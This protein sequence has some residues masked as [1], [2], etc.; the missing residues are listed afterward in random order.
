MV[1]SRLPKEAIIPALKSSVVKGKTIGFA[2][3]AIRLIVKNL[4]DYEEMM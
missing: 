1:P 3:Q 2:R 4:W